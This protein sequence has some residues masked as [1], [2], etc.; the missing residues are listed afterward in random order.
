VHWIKLTA[1]P[2]PRLSLVRKVSD[3]GAD[4]VGPFSSKRTAERAVAALHDAFPVRQCTGRMPKQPRLTPCVLA[5]MGRC[6][7][8]CDGSVSLQEYDAVVRRLRTSLLSQPDEVVDLIST[9]MSTLATQERFED[10]GS[11]RDRLAAYLRGTARSQRLRALTRCPEVVAARRA[12]DGRWQV[13]V[14]RHGRLAAAGVIPSGAHAGHWVE[15][16]RAGADTVLAGPGPT[17]AA[18]AEETEKV[19]RWLESEGIRLVRIDG[20]WTCPIGGATRHLKVHDAVEESRTALVP[21]EERRSLRPVHQP[22]R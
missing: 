18:T 14:V 20:E 3:D 21:F 19:L 9:R 22:V 10:A 15:Q 11:L 12:D 1:E 7:S 6:L 13:H 2:W 16:L 5:Q 17:P 8:P 4:Y